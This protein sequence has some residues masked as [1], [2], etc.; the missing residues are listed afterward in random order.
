MREII[1]ED[2]DVLEQQDYYV[3]GL[4]QTVSTSSGS[5]GKMASSMEK[6]YDRCST[7]HD[8]MDT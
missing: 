1:N 8:E 5:F 6:S 4:R 2:C 7:Y 3:E